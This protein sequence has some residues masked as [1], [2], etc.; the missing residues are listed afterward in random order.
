MNKLGEAAS[1]VAALY[2]IHGGEV[3]DEFLVPDTERLEVPGAAGE[4]EVGS[5]PTCLAAEG[6]RRRFDSEVPQ[7]VDRSL[8]PIGVCAHGHPRAR[9]AES[10]EAEPLAQ[11]VASSPLIFGD[12]ERHDDPAAV[13]RPGRIE[14]PEDTIGTG[15]KQLP[16]GFAQVPPHLATD[17]LTAEQPLIRQS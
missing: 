2:G 5:Q 1:D 9:K 17:P 8:L 13:P 14:E 6:H 12:R 10:G 16:A 4:L 11:P 7:G 15:A 3:R